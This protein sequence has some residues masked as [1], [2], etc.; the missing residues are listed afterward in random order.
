[1][2]RLT[3]AGYLARIYEFFGN[4][5]PTGSTPF[6]DVPGGQAGADVACIYHLGIT[7]GTSSTTYSP[8]T[9]VNR[10]QLVTFL[11]RLW[12]ALGETCPEDPTPFV[13]EEPAWAVDG[14]RC[15]FGLGVTE[16]TSAT[17]FSPHDD[18]IRLHLAAFASRFAQLAA[19]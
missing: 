15:M 16:G 17:T 10:A 7:T 13:D 14:I 6:V 19:E 3:M 8:D 2:D 18:V 1:M 4:E 9:I 5:C 11:A 12:V